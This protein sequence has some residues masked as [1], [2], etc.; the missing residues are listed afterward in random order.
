[1]TEKE[2]VRRGTMNE[3]IT[4]LYAAPGATPMTIADAVVRGCIKD[5][6]VLESVIW[7]IQQ[8]IDHELQGGAEH[9]KS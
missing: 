6:E 3:E 8:Y 1:M 5:R 4:K 9:G 2:I 7:F